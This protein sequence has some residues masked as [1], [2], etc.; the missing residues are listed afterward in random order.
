MYR[1]CAWL[2]EPELHAC[3]STRET[4][5][6]TFFRSCPGTAHRR[7]F[8]TAQLEELGFADSPFEAWSLY[9][10]AKAKEVDST[11]AELASLTLEH[12]RALDEMEKLA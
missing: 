4:G 1:I 2:K 3:Q 11:Q 5:A 6:L 12:S 10:E 7:Q 8:R 9:A